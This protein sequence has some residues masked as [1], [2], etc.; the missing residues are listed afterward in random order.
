MLFKA[1]ITKEVIDKSW[2]CGVKLKAGENEGKMI[3]TPEN[4]AFAVVFHQLGINARVGSVSTHFLTKDS[5]HKHYH[6]D[7]TSQKKLYISP[8]SGDMIIN[9]RKFD[10]GVHAPEERYEL[11]GNEC[12]VT[13][14]DEVLNH[15]FETADP[16]HIAKLL[17]GNEIL[18]PIC[19]ENEIQ[20]DNH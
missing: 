10:D 9:I 4:C 15:Y 7:L 8:H 20:S 18:Q 3:H 17:M 5:D 1:K 19:K 2:L 13:I 12:E 14:P 11:V 16:E 6:T